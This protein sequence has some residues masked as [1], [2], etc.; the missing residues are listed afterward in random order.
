M[1][2]LRISTLPVLTRALLVAGCGLPLLAAPAA[3]QDREQD[4]T[5]SNEELDRDL[6]ESLAE[7]YSEEEAPSE[8]AKE[9]HRDCC[10]HDGHHHD[11]GPDDRDGHDRLRLRFGGLAAYAWTGLSNLEISH[12]EGGSGGGVIELAQEEDDDFVFDNGAGMY[13]AWIGIGRYV[14]LQGG[15]FHGRFGDTNALSN[16]SGGTPGFTFGGSRFNNG[17]I[18]EIN[19]ELRVADFDVVVHPLTLKWIRLDFSLGARYAYWETRVERLNRSYN[20]E[21]D[22]I[23]GLIPMVGFGITVSPVEP[24]AFFLRGKV[25]TIE[26]EREGGYYRRTNGRRRYVE[27]KNREHTSAELDAGMTFTI[28]NTFGFIVGARIQYIELERVVPDRSSR[29]EGYASSLYAGVLL[30]F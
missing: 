5:P 28:A 6:D 12:R 21:E 9:D 30:N 20:K 29:V 4:F 18:V 13:R 10:G 2:R 24:L 8:A 15:W 19:Q 7:E 14:S 25:G 11:E 1:S 23:E 27:P 26:Y 22:R 3:A 16:D 17:D